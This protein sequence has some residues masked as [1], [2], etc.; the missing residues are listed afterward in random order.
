MIVR[1][2]RSVLYPTEHTPRHSLPVA[3]NRLP[4]VPLDAPPPTRATP[5]IPLAPRPTSQISQ[6]VTRH[7]VAQAL[8][9]QVP[10]RTDFPRVQPPLSEPSGPSASASA[11]TS[12]YA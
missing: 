8:Q 5:P 7:R 11:S 9:R 4:T 1:R 2:A 12:A 6:Q 3:P 10:V